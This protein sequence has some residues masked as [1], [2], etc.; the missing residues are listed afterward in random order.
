MRVLAAK[1]VGRSSVAGR[2]GGLEA[3]E[4]VGGRGVVVVENGLGLVEVEVENGFEWA[5][6]EVENG[7]VSLLVVGVVL[8]PNRL[9]PMLGCMVLVLCSSP[10]LVLLP[11]PL[12]LDLSPTL[13]TRTPRKA[14]TLP[15]LRRQVLLLQLN[16]YSRLS[17][18]GKCSGKSPLSWSNNVIRSLQTLHFARVAGGGFE[19]SSHV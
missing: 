2:W 12:G 17:C 10:L 11:L 18:P 8:L 19:E 4:V 13:L 16:R 5:L 15:S 7:F 9:S 1:V 6:E 14:L 3:R